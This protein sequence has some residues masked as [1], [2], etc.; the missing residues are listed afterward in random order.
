MKK[1]LDIKA[2]M[3]GKMP[4]EGEIQKISIENPDGSVHLTGDEFNKELSENSGISV[5]KVE[6]I[7]DGFIRDLAKRINKDKI[8]K[9]FGV[10]TIHRE[11][12][13]DLN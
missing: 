5:E 3:T 7:I 13:E 8:T 12:T 10:H 4:K 9:V 11:D 6:L 1:K 2:R